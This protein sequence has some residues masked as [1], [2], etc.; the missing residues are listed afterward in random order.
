MGLWML[1]ERLEERSL[2][3]VGDGCAAVA[4]FYG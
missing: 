1:E 2:S 4:D 3:G